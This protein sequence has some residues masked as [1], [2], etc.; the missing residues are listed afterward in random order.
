MGAPINWSIW[1]CGKPVVEFIHRF[2]KPEAVEDMA[3]AILNNHPEA[4]VAEITYDDCHDK[5][6]PGGTILRDEE[7]TPYIKKHW[8]QC[9]CGRCRD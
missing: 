5:H 9:Q 7:G 8:S 6:E 3:I 1:V 2:L 4:D